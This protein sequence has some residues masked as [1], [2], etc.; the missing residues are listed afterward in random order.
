MT[1]LQGAVSRIAVDAPSIQSGVKP[2][3]SKGW[4]RSAREQAVHLRHRLRRTCGDLRFSQTARIGS[5]LIDIT[6]ATGLV[7]D[8]K[9]ILC[10]DL[11]PRRENPTGSGMGIVTPQARRIRDKSTTTGSNQMPDTS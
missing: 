11:R 2:P 4:R 1:A 7:D 9:H 3:H 10:V 5:F 8:S 6:Q